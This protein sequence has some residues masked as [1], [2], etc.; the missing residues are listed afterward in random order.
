M[1]NLNIFNKI[2]KLN[3][4]I[5]ILDD[6]IS[7]AK[8]SVNNVISSD[9]AALGNVSDINFRLNSI[10]GENIALVI[11]PLILIVFYFKEKSSK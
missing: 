8:N 9:N 11:I 1:E 4:E 10:N 5:Q 3:K 2:E 7:K 6:H